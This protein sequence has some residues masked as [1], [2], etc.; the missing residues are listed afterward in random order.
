MSMLLLWICR[1]NVNG[2]S[3]SGE[4]PISTKMEEDGPEMANGGPA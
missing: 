3:R 4:V 2:K 1:T